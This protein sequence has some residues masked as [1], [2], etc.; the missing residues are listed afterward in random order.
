MVIFDKDI[1]V[2]NYN[3]VVKIN[4]CLKKKIYN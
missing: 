1:F 3:T 2:E 4:D